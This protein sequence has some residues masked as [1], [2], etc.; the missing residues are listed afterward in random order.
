[1]TDRVMAISCLHDVI[2]VWSPIYEPSVWGYVGIW[3][4]AYRDIL[5]L[6]IYIKICLPIY[7]AR[8]VDEVLEVLGP[9]FNDTFEFIIQIRRQKWCE[10]G[11]KGYILL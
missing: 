3:G 11:V 2:N 6:S 4:A 1:M 8:F 7:G 5:R 9:L 10:G